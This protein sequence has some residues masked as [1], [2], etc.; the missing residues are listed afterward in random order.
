MT[1]ELFNGNQ[2]ACG[3]T[4]SGGSESIIM[5]MLAYRE[6]AKSEKCITKPNIVAPQTAHAALAKACYYF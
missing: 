6:W 2:E 1:V 3:V 5:A 4:T